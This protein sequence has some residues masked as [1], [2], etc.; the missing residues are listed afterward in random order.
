MND[1][2]MAQAYR[3]SLSPARRQILLACSIA[4][5]LV[6][7]CGSALAEPVVESLNAL[8]ESIRREHNLPAL[9]AA[10][11]RRDGMIAVGAVGVR[12]M[13]SNDPITLDD[14]FHIGSC[15]KSMTA[16]VCAILVDQGRLSW[17]TTI[18]DTFSELR[19]EIRPEFRGVTLEQLLA[20]R[21][22]L[23]SDR[24]PDRWLMLRL[25]MLTG[26][27]QEQRRQFLKIILKRDLA[28]KPGTEFLYSNFGYTIA[29]AMAEQISGKAWEQLL[30][31]LLLQ[32]LGITSAGFGAPGTPGT[33]D[34]PWGHLPVESNWVPVPP[35][36]LADNPAVISPAGCVHLTI[37]DWAKYAAFHL[38]GVLG[39][40]QLLKPETFKR[41]HSD[42]YAQGYAL[43]WGLRDEPS[44]GGAVLTHAGSNSMWF[45]WIWI[46]RYAG[47]RFR[48]MSEKS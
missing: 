3:T 24:E 30:S 46:A 8:L 38:R 23:P 27:M 29:G 26:P 45:A 28:A 41:L 48:A 42:A 32:P 47:K 39:Q 2:A 37:S 20:H 18:G 44:R 7:P 25:R 40:G 13:G 11:V 19:G 15:T 14:R 31:E 4:G 22:G 9:A 10:V 1:P 43:G 5:L 33:V 36:P 16:T 17:A 12:K 21:S 6:P 34:Q 35:G